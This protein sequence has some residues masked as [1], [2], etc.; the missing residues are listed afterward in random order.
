MAYLTPRTRRA[1]TQRGLTASRDQ[2]ALQSQNYIQLGPLPANA[3]WQG[4]ANLV[5]QKS[6]VHVQVKSQ[7][8][9]C[10]DS[11]ERRKVKKM[12]FVHMFSGRC[13]GVRRKDG[14]K[15]FATDVSLSHLPW[16]GAKKHQ[17]FG[18]ALLGKGYRPGARGE[19]L[20][21]LSREL[22]CMCCPFAPHPIA[23]S[24]PSCIGSFLLL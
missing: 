12:G 13:V 9:I 2:A 14:N 20:R 11:W 5:L 6:Q 4:V 7:G 21:P 15:L 24:F 16:S 19:S 18:H 1:S 22:R 8:Q 17:G 23:L 10:R 3:L